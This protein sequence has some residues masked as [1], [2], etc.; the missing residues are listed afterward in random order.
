MVL[1]PQD[2]EELA[3]IAL[4][5]GEILCRKTDFEIE[6]RIPRSVGEGGMRHTFLRNGMYLGIL[7]GRLRQPV[8]SERQYRTDAPL[9][10]TF[11]LSGASRIRTKSPTLTNTKA[12][13]AEISGC[14]Y[15]Y[16]LPE[17]TDIEQWPSDEWCQAMVIAAPA[18][19]FRSFSQRGPPLA[20]RC[21]SLPIRA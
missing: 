18:N 2:L 1:S 11:Y 5:N 3:A 19:Y 20:S 21:F 7:N 13:Y 4:Q 15:V 16:H 9:T 12:D 6:Q 14:H 8:Q 17:T 10:A